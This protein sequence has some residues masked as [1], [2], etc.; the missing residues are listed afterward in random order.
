MIKRYKKKV[1]QEITAVQL[2][3]DT[4]GFPFQKWG[5]TQFCKQGDWIVDNNGECYTIDAK[6]FEKTYSEVSPGRYVKSAPVWAEV[7][8]TNGAVPTK[9]G[10]SAFKVGDYIV[11]N[12]EDETDGYCM[13]SEKFES[14]YE[15]D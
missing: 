4:A 8:H 13:S 10:K 2:N 15:L 1:M 5:A 6:S 3:L 14:M 12:N 9:E 11:Y 7:A